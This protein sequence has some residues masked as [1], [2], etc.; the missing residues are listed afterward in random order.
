QTDEGCADLRRWFLTEHR[1]DELT[2]FENK[3]SREIDDHG[4]ERRK[5]IFPDVHPQFKFGFFKLLKGVPSPSGHAFEGRFYLHNPKDIFTPPIR[6][7]AEMIYR[8]SPTNLAFMEFRSARDYQL[9]AKRSE[10]HTSEL[11]SRFDL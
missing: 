6:Y 1:L 2:S 8:F 4:K 10:E 11:Q 3:G 9:G 7:V 5:Q